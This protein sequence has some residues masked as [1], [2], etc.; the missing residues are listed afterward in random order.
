MKQA[1]KDQEKTQAPLFAEKSSAKS[2][3]GLYCRY[4]PSVDFES[5]L[6]GLKLFVPLAD[7]Y[8]TY[9]LVHSV[10]R[11]RNCDTWRLGRAYA[12]DHRFENETALTP[13]G[14]EW[15]MALRLKDRPDFIGGYAHGDEIYTSL[16]VTMDGE[17]IGME[18]L[19]DL[20]RFDKMIITVESLGYDPNDSATQALRHQKEYVIDGDG[21]T[22]N[23]TVEWLN[24]Y[25][26]GSSYLAMMPP[27][28]TLTDH[29][30]T[31]VD[32]TPKIA[33]GHRGYVL[34]ASQATVYGDASRIAF[35]MS[36]PKYPSLP[37]GDR[38]LLSDNG[39][40]PY[41]KM[42]FV[43]CNGAD[44]S[45]GEVWESTTQYRIAER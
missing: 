9:H 35:S 40:Y 41:N 44:V 33:N 38:F 25:T 29:F 39:G 7:G 20:T 28:K 34:G 37:G 1:Y 17:S 45:K 21:I 16:S 43:V 2:E 4:D 13:H 6:G 15:D 27:L 26:L 23:Q 8:A 42:Y 32:P 18:S 30:Y 31:D 22:L 5:A 14:A 19:T 24:D 11:D 36:V 12:V 10:N 3:K